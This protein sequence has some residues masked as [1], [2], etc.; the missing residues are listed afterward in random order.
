MEAVY[1]G[2]VA[3]L[4]GAAQGLYENNVRVGTVHHLEGFYF[5][6][7]E[8]VTGASEE[9]LKAALEQWANL[10]KIL[11]GIKGSL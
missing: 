3:V 10:H 2:Y 5:V 7:S 6:H 4:G 1:E 8:D 11:G 9:S